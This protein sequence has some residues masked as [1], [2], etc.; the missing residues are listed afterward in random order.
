MSSDFL[1][2]FIT[3]ELYLVKDST[4][5]PPQTEKIVEQSGIAPAPSPST[6]AEK[7]VSIHHPL[8]IVSAPM[9]TM[10]HSLLSKVLRAVNHHIDEV[11][12]VETMPTAKVTFDKMLVFLPASNQPLYQPYQ[13]DQGEQLHAAPLSTFHDNQQEKLK[14]WNALKSWFKIA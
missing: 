6:D 11:E 14:L 8:I 9:N 12:I 1:P 5:D 7:P 3:E 13:T 2:Y 4:I 10:D